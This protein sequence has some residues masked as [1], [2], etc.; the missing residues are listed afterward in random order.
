MKK[1]VFPYFLFLA[2]AI[3]AQQANDS[4]ATNR[5]NEVV[6]ASGR[7][8]LPLSENSRSI[9]IITAE[10]IRQSGVNNVADL[11][12]QVAGVDVRIRGVD[13][14]Q[15]DL[16]IRGGS[17]DQ[18]LLLIDG[19]K[20]EDAQTGHHTLNFVL[21]LEVIERIEIVKGP[22]ARVFGQNAFTGAI[23]IVT[24]TSLS[25]TAVLAARVGSFEQRNGEATFGTSNENSSLL[26]H[27]SIKSSDGYRFNTDFTNH[28]VFL[29]GQFNKTTTPINVIASFSD[30]KFG[31]N[32]FYALPSYADQYEETQASL[33]A[34]ST[35]IQKDKWVFK[36]RL[37]WR[38][39]Q[40]MYL[41][42]RNNPA[43]YRNLHITHK[44]GASLDASYYSDL[45][46]TGLGIDLA[47]VSIDSNNLGERERFVTTLFAEHRF[48]LLN[49]S[50]DI[51]PGLAVSNYTDFGTQFFPG[52]DIG[53]AISPQFRLYGNAGYTYRIP[54]FTDLYYSDST[55]IGNENLKA[56]EAITEEFGFRWTNNKAQ[57]S[58]AFFNRS[59][60]NLI[61][62]IRSTAEG[63]YEA[64]N[65][66]K[67]NTQGIELEVKTQF[68]S[69]NQPQLFT[70]GYTYLNDDVEQIN[71]DFSRYSINSLRHHLTFNQV[72]NFNKNLSL[73][74][75]YKLGQRPQRDAYHVFDASLRYMIR[76]VE[77][78]LSFFNIFDEVYSESNLVPLPLSNGTFGLRFAF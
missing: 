21:P 25:T 20:L 70:L 78:N 62:Y 2:V 16:Y 69:G 59:A 41:F 64:T 51:T 33:V 56:E 42:V 44:V 39:G 28:N 4:I 57:I 45:G 52:I 24:K 77:L 75:N 72:A 11:L 19:I 6:V 13:G 31:A 18:T 61:D 73:T 71:V 49:N 14:T 7:I 63:P 38:R 40:D 55:T 27:Y 53:L 68:I 5:L 3:Y 48:Q 54:T 37:Y 74:W 9:Q 50:L 46:T 36:P 1:Y 67:V 60:E 76:A 58:M 32:G 15:A 29:K 35:R 17:F 22:A 8:D 66:R 12:Q 65:I 30:R 26:A 10:T 47:R 43:I 23:N 34:L